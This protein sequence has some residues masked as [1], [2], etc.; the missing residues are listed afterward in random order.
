MSGRK[1]IQVDESEWYRIQRK[2]QQLKEVQRNI[3]R[4]I[5]DVRA[6]TR[7]DIDR[8][9]ANVQERQRRHEQA[10]SSLSEQ[11]RQLEE[12][13]TRRLRE[14]A[15]ALHRALDE[16]AGHIR[17]ETREQ[18]ARQRAETMQAIAAERAERR[19]EMTALSHEVDALK[20]DRARSEEMVRAWLGDAR[21]MAALIADTLPHERYAPG[22]LARLTGRLAT[23]EHNVAEGRFEAALAVVQE[24]YHSLSDLRV[25]TEQRELERCSAQSEAVEALVR[26]EKLIDGNAQR[27]VIGPDGRALAGYQLDVVHWSDGELDA[28]RRETLDALGRARDDTTDTDELLGLRERETARLE[29]SLGDAVERAGMRQLASQIRV[30]LADAVART[31]SEYAYYDLVEGDYEGGDE[32]G[33]YYAKMRNGDNE[34]VVDVAQAGPDSEQCVIRVLSYDQDV[35]AEAELLRRAQAVQQA[36]EADGL[37]V[38][39]PQCEQGSPGDIVPDP[40]RRTVPSPAP[41]GEP[42]P[43]PRAVEEPQERTA[44]Q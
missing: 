4:L 22:E 7:A 37:K 2:A 30:N 3:P 11:T 13:T 44:T 40:G 15:T 19:A 18:L 25:E 6:Q 39:E 1:R 31:L 29:Q 33:R 23:G 28:L 8:T 12:S 27:P 35:T 43:A 9:F 24:A 21:T 17:A 41:H 20:A 38:S 14:Q 36:L 34:L 5:E 16:T 10:M 32:R 26:V 42:R